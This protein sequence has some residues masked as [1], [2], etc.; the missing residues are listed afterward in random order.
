M[1][2]Y[3][4][5]AMSMG[6]FVAA[7]FWIKYWRAT[8]DALFLFF[9]VA[10]ALEGASRAFFALDASPTEGSPVFYLARL[11]AYLLI[12]GAIVSKNVKRSAPP[13]R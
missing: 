7:L 8:R 10:F 1:N 12:L 3:L 2:T 13:S 6:F 9:A 4:L 5:S 11:V